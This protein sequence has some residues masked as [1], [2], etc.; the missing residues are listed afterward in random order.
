MAELRR[1][2]QAEAAG[3]RQSPG[4]AD[5]GSGIMGELQSIAS[6]LQ[7]LSWRNMRP[8]GE[9]FEQFK[10]PRAWTKEVLD[11]RITTNMLHYRGNYCFVVFGSILVFIVSSPA[12]LLVAAASLALLVFLFPTETSG[13]AVVVSG[14]AVSAPERRFIAIVLIL[15]LLATTGAAAT[16]LYASGLA[17]ATCLAHAVFRPRNLKS[18]FNRLQEEARANAGAGLGSL[19]SGGGSAQGGDGGGG[20]AAG[21]RRGSGQGARR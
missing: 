18:K 11:E 1:R 16:L 8:W 10:P 4:T 21:L 5:P 14:R 2:F 3:A 12:L 6:E 19:L 7:S 20:G 13:R 15:T 9:F 17:A